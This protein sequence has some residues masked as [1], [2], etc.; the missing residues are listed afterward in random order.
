MFHNIDVQKK[1][2]KKVVIFSDWI[3]KLLQCIIRHAHVEHP[4][5]FCAVDG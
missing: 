1:N 5:N 2:P 3:L 4:L